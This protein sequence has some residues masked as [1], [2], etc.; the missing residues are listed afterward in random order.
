MIKADNPG[1]VRVHRLIIVN[2]VGVGVAVDIV[3]IAL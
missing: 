3:E 2:V 1:R